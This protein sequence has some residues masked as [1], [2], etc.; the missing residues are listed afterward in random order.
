MKNMNQ[1]F[2]QKKIIH[3]NTDQTSCCHQNVQFSKFSSTKENKNIFFNATKR[4]NPSQ[5]KI[6][7]HHTLKRKENPD[8]Q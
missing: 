1:Y 8:E 3:K 5:N 7:F 6:Y 4:K 2:I